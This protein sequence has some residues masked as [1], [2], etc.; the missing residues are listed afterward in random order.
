MDQYP[1]DFQGNLLVSCLFSDMPPALPT[2]PLPDNWPEQAKSGLLFAIALAHRGVA[3]VRGW[4]ADSRIARVRLA[5]QND[6]LRAELAMLKEELRIKD[7]R[8][9]RIPPA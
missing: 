2:I 8:S 7:A 4:C 1:G 3:Y 5:A 9:A 6:R